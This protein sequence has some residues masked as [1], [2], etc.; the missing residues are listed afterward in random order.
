MVYSKT[1]AELYNRAKRKSQN[2]AWF[3]SHCKT[4]SKRGELVKRLQQ[5]MS[6]DVYGKCGPLKCKRIFNRTEDDPCKEK[7]ENYRFY[8][9]F[10]NSLWQD[11]V[12][13]KLF[14]AME[15]FIIPIVYGGANYSYFAPPKSYIDANSF[16]TVE[17]LANYLTHLSANPA[18][19]IKYFWWRKYYR[20]VPETPIT[21]FCDLCT[22]LHETNVSGMTA[23]WYDD[24]HG[25]WFKKAKKMMKS[26]EF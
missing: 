26:I 3:V 10:E 7:L 9:S 12:T 8:L 17:E 21:K 5:Y 4:E 2:I 13:E 24:I 20:V 6:V 18:E 25:W 1:D 11:Y 14:L 16:A 19:Y 22:K 23:K 15:S